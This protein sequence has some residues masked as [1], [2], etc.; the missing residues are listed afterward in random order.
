MPA[1]LGVQ[2]VNPAFQPHT[3]PEKRG[4]PAVPP[5]A[6]SQKVGTRVAGR[7]RARQARGVALD[8]DRAG[9]GRLNGENALLSDSP[10]NDQ[11]LVLDRYCSRWRGEGAVFEIVFELYEPMLQRKQAPSL[12]RRHRLALA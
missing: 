11:S 3:L 4:C 7:S 5:K 12:F 1:V 8:Y 6:Y 2:K 9:R 10:G